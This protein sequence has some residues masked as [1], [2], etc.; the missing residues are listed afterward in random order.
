MGRP[1]CSAIF[2]EEFSFT[3]TN[4]DIPAAS[5]SRP[6]FRGLEMYGRL[7]GWTFK[8]AVNALQP[9][10][11][12]LDIG[13]GYGI[14]SLQ[15][16]E[17]KNVVAHAINAQNFWNFLA[18]APPMQVKGRVADLVESLQL[19]VGAF[20]PRTKATVDSGYGYLYAW[21]KATPNMISNARAIV[22][23]HF[24]KLRSQG[25]FVFHTGYAESALPRLEGNFALITDLYGAFLYS[26]DRMHLLD[27]IYDKLSPTG[28]AVIKLT[29]ASGGGVTDKVLLQNGT[30]ISLG[31]FLVER[32]PQ[33]F[34]LANND[35]SVLVVQKNSSIDSLNLALE[36][37]PAETKIANFTESEYPVIQWKLK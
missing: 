12:I 35:Q 36:L 8:N 23:S 21:D 14:S 15:I 3:N 25:K 18:A 10:D 29:T 9:G 24:N 5:Y 37:T 27:L 17:K 31:E 33:V 26:S 13:A 34:S 6:H 28:R 30:S 20:V 7:L 22:L 2:S 32:N 11:R 19:E 1:L 16:A 4:A